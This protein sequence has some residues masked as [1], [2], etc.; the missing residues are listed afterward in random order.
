[1]PKPNISKKE[2]EKRKQNEDLRNLERQCIDELE[3]AADASYREFVDLCGGTS[4]RIDM[5]FKYEY[6][7]VVLGANNVPADQ[8]CIDITDAYTVPVPALFDVNF[9]NCFD[10]QPVPKKKRLKE[11]KRKQR[12]KQ[13]NELQKQYSKYMH[14]SLDARPDYI[15]HGTNCEHAT[16]GIDKFLDSIDVH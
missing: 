14:K 2:A 6:N 12:L 9:I 13:R 11:K 15:L 10:A 5:K 7:P 1:M 16:E 8:V 4:K 3:N